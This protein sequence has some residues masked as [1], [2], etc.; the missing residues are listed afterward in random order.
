MEER[1]ADSFS[2]SFLDEYAL[3]L[4]VSTSASIGPDEI[5]ARFVLT[6]KNA[7]F[8]GGLRIDPQQ[9]GHGMILVPFVC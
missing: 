1:S 6:C 8:M 4:V 9:I 2:E 3:N 5:L 7:M